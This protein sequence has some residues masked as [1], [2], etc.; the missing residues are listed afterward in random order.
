[1]A[2]VADLILLIPNMFYG[3]LLIE[4]K[5]AKGKQSPSQKQW[6]K[7]VTEQGEYKYV[8][9]HSLDEFMNEVEDYLKYY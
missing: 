9:C 7:L 3:A 5:T 4:M 6:E 1:M 8:V 2:G